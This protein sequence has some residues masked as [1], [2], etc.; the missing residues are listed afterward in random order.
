MNQPQLAPP[1]AGLPWPKNWIAKYVIYPIMTRK[2]TWEQSDEQFDRMTS[3]ILELC[4]K[5]DEQAL[6]QRVLVPKHLPGIEDSSRY[7][8]IAMTVE[9]LV[10]VQPQIAQLVVALSNGTVPDVVASTATVKPVGGRT[11]QA[12]IAEFT[13]A[14]QDARTLVQTQVKDRASKSRLPHPWFGPMTAHEWHWLFGG[15]MGIH[16]NQIKWIVKLSK[17]A[18]TAN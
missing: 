5:L 7:W 16:Y 11:A 2:V 12:A 4:K 6:T 15:H 9:H 1:G 18:Q 14:M 13:K 8:S 17:R 10:I 3:K